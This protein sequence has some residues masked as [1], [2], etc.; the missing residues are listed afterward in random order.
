MSKNKENCQRRREIVK[1]A[2]PAWLTDE[3]RTMMKNM[4]EWTKEY[5]KGVSVK[6]ERFHVDHI[7]PLNHPEVCGLNVPWNLQII[8][9]KDNHRKSNKLSHDPIAGA[10]TM[11]MFLTGKPSDKIR[12]KGQYIKG[13]T[14]NEHGSRVEKLREDPTLASDIFA[15]SLAEGE[16]FARTVDLLSKAFPSDVDFTEQAASML[17]RSA[18]SPAEMYKYLKD[19]MPYYQA[20]VGNTEKSDGESK[21]IIEILRPD[22]D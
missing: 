20:K 4:Q 17:L 21:I 19:F 22:E 2:T 10:I 16:E 6:K 12:Y 9:E 5:N 3:H 8:K 11:E 13:Q 7:I 1:Q 18:K 14:G 15:Q